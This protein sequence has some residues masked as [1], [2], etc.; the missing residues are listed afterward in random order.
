MNES[1]SPTL[2]PAWR[3]WLAIRPKT[4]PAAIAPVLLGASIALRRGGF[5]L[6]PA[7]AAML[8]AVLI[9]IATNLVNDVVDFSRGADNA[10]RTGPA[11]ATQTGMLSPRQVWAGA[12]AAFGLAA[13]IG[14]Y[15]ILIA[16]WP[17][18]ILGVAA[19]IAGAAYTA[20]PFP[21]AYHG[22][23]G[24]FVLLFFGYG[25]VA[26]TVYVTAGSLPPETWVA[27]TAAGALTVNILVVNNVRD[28]ETDRAAGRR[29]IPVTLGRAGGEWQY[30]LM[31]AVA[32]ASPVVLICWDLASPWAMLTF[33]SLPFAV[34]VWHKLRSGLSGQGLNPLL[35]K[36]AQVLLL[37][38]I[39]LSIG[40]LI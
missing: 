26:G 28:V 36:T 8:I 24:L 34:G 22:L 18:L 3:W 20:G 14:L 31:V 19:L 5:T 11:R 1:N 9:Q 37:Y 17:A 2:S 27:A 12:I 40:L 4:L 16:G 30:A 10:S 39:L 21:L 15:L 32:Y 33:L 7:L 6:L 23:G 35:G 25:A 38:C 29:N 13:L